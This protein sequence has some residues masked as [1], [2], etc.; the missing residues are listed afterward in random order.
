MSEESPTGLDPQAHPEAPLERGSAATIAQ[1]PER[2]PISSVALVGNEMAY[3]RECLESTWISSCGE[4]VEAFEEK[5]AALWEVEH[6][7][8]VNT[9]TAALHLALLA[10][11]V[12]PGEEVIVPSLTYVAT[13]SAVSYCGATPVFVDSEP[14]SWNLDPAAVEAAIGPRT[15]G[16]VAVHL[17]GHP[18]QIDALQAIAARRELFLLEDAAQ[19]HGSCYRGRPVGSLGNAGT[20]SFFGGKLLTTGEGGMLVTNDASLAK[21]ALQ[22]R[23]HARDPERRYHSSRVGFNYRMTNVAA[24]IGLGQL[25][26]FD[27]HVA[28]RRANAALYRSRLLGHPGL[29]FADPEPW[30][31]SVEWLTSVVLSHAGEAERDRVIN[32]LDGAGIEARAVFE[33]VHLQE[34]FAD[35]DTGPLP[36]A[37]RLAAKGLSLP[38]GALLTNEQIDRVCEA[39]LRAL[40]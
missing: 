7:V 24:A 12:S 21:T 16:I 19:A 11:G 38:S 37:E 4:F 14:G 10:L 26:R 18:A 17:Y 5:F 1:L 32:E 9:G 33:P 22:L 34:I 28:R 6:A 31:Q 29:E 30:A 20:F 13:A 36:V 39:L 2:L 23:N 40:P 35:A 27:W 15:V 8:A 3:V 25:E